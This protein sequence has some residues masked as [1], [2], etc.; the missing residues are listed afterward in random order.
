MSRT[1]GSLLERQAELEALRA[2]L[3]GVRTGSSALVMLVGAAGVGKSRLLDQARRMAEEAG[4]RVL[5]G[6]GVS[7]EQEYAFGV[8]R[9]LFEPVLVRSP[10]PQRDEWLS[11]AAGDATVALGMDQGQPAP[12]DG[13][14]GDYAVLHGLYWLT[15]NLTRSGPVV[16]LI[17]DLHWSDEPSLRYLAYLLPRLED[18]PLA[19]IAATRPQGLGSSRLLDAVALDPGCML[20]QPADLSVPATASLLE[21]RF[22]QAPE[23]EFSAACHRATGGNPLLLQELVRALKAEG[24]S[25]S[26]GS[27]PRVGHIGSRAVSRRVALELTRLPPD[28]RRVAEAMAVLAPAASLE[29]AARLAG[30]E[31]VRAA[32]A[33]STLVSIE[34]LR[35]VREKSPREKYDYIHPLV[36]QAVYEQIRPDQHDGYHRE[37]ARLLAETDAGP[38]RIATHLLRLPP[39]TVPQTVSLL[40]DAAA[41][42][43]AHGS[44]EGAFTYL[45]RALEEQL[46]RD[47]RSTVL[48]EAAFAALRSDLSLGISYFEEAL[49]FTEDPQHR[50]RLAAPLGLALLYVE[51]ADAAVDVLTRAAE[52]LPPEADDLWRGLQAILLNIPTVA[53]GWD[54]LGRELPA[55][56]RL[57]PSHSI[58]AL[59]LEGMIA[60]HET[61]QADPQGVERARRVIAH[62]EFAA[63]ASQGATT[64]VGAYFALLLGDLDQG[65]AAHTAL[66]EEARRSGS[67]PTLFQGFGFR[68]LGWLRRGDLSEAEADVR[69][70]IR[71]ALLSHSTV[72]IS[73]LWAI[74]CEIFVERGSLD[75]AEA[76]LASAEVPEEL[77]PS[78]MFYWFMQAKAR[79]LHAQGRDEEAL[80]MAGRAGARF[81]DNGGCNPA[82][83]AWRSTAAQSLH[84]LGR[85]DEAV[86]HAA[87]EIE[88][89]RRWGADFALGRALR[90]GGLVTSG[91]EALGF[92]REAVDVLRSGHAP[93]EYAKALIDLGA[94]LRRGNARVEAR[95]YLS[96]GLRLATGLGTAP[97]VELAEAELRAAG[98]RPR[99]SPAEG[100][101]ALTP[102]EQRVAEL[103]VQGLTNRAIA[104]KLYVTVKTVEVHLGSCYRKLGI[105]GRAQLG[106]YVESA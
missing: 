97:L 28:G 11:G 5:H 72:G 69:E 67:L 102:S 64:A 103:A 26:A 45:K 24:L 80:D 79:L 75:E 14:V 106:S 74:L 57:P 96:E 36:Q 98:A 42:A 31:V 22:G 100:A 88:L 101:E 23:E 95:P 81:A 43:L 92:L 93:L 53:V 87:E 73:M 61:Y 68:S 56:R 32:A 51:R 15:A 1:D 63:A 76:A 104:Q 30:V 94:A 6:R 71:I 7:L 33:A 25:P 65:I 90:V 77:P 35:P 54:H 50:A 3:D 83:T 48:T 66:I 62:P 52:D 17:D 18:V 13:A 21:E 55:L 85:T 37:A 105:T 44:H 29:H 78:G 46:S 38:E 20:L 82:V 86:R 12:G 27:A 70:A 59:M 58:G 2:R 16:L 89:A 19:V 10:P 84:A 4:M 9:Q 8:V 91:D 49:T 34:L 99:R 47:E 60:A 41:H 39:G 40:R